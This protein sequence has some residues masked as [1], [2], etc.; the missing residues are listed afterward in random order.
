MFE[1]VRTVTEFRVYYDD[2]GRVITYALGDHSVGNYIVITRE[3]FLESRFD[4]IVRDGRLIYTHLPNLS[5][6]YEQNSSTGFQTSKYDINIPADHTDDQ[7]GYWKL[8]S[9]EH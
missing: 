8:T 9:H 6:V 4:A 5:W 2:E 7:I 1:V 3:Q